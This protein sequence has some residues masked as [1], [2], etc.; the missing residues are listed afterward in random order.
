MSGEPPSRAPLRIATVRRQFDRRAARLAQHDALLREVERRLLDKLDPIKLAPARVV[1]IGC[2]AGHSQALLRRRFPQADW[3]GVDLSAAMLTSADRGKGLLS[4]WLRRDRPKRVQADAAALPLA[5]GCAD[6]VFSNLMLHWH[7]QPHLL[8][9]EF[10]R[11]LRVGGLLLFSCFGP[12]SVQELRAA[13]RAWPQA[14]PMPFIDMHDFGDMLVAQGFA[15]PVMDAER[16]VL[17][18]PSP[19]ALR[20][21]A[22][23][24]GANPRDDRPA[25][26]PATAVA[27]SVLSAL[28]AQPAAAAG[29]H[30]L[31]FEIAYG[32]AWKPAPRERGV[33]AVPLDRLRE[34]LPQRRVPAKS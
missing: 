22:A 3:V 31:S 6:L 17:T 34:T 16:I 20:R 23:A 27:R 7:P 32:H 21:E 26:L 8:F 10:K 15:D 2:G 1:D 14:R 25:A 33:A 24:L 13:F 19:Q 28:S 30:A 29:R 5:D 12:D 11:V 4:R 18:Y 9:A